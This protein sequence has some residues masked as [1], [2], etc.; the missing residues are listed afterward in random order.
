MSDPVNGNPRHRLGS[1]RPQ[2]DRHAPPL[3]EG[4]W[5]AI[6]PGFALTFFDLLYAEYLTLRS[7]ITDEKVVDLLE[8]IHKERLAYNLTWSDIYTFDLALVDVRPPETLIR[9]AYEARAKYRSVAGQ[10]EFDDYQA[11][12]PPDLAAIRIAPNNATDAEEAVERD[13]RADIGFL[14]SRIYLY[15]ALSPVR[16]GMRSKLSQK[17]LIITGMVTGIFALFILGSVVLSLISQVGQNLVLA[18]TVASVVFAGFIGGGVSALQRIQNLPSDGDALF[19]LSFLV[20]S[21]RAFLLPPLLGGVFALLLFMLFA[22]GL[23]EGTTFPKI[24]TVKSR[25]TASQSQPGPTQTPERARSASSP[26]TSAASENQ[27]TPAAETAPLAPTPATSTRVEAP[28]LQIRDFLRETG[29]A[30][31]VSYALLIIWSFMA[32]FAERLV[33]DMLNRMVAEDEATKR[34]NT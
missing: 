23:L 22:A 21:W 33:P 19:N 25:Q 4:F 15:Y 32:G 13:L 11:S 6:V 2:R 18:T 27:G 12:N 20:N 28:V 24:N 9:K 5:K 3:R 30:D 26:A 14:L 17:I 29:P 10:K 31:G 7:R 1:A 34:T 8:S 16:D